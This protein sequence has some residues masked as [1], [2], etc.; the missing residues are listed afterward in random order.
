[1]KPKSIAIVGA[2]ETTRLGVIP[3]MSQIQLHADAALNAMARVILL[4]E[5]SAVLGPWLDRREL[6]GADV[7]AL[8]DQGRLVPAVD[9]VNAQRLRRTMRRE[10]DRIW[11]E[12]DCFI[13]PAT[14][15]TAPRIGDTTVRLGGVDVRFRGNEVVELDLILKHDRV[16]HATACRGGAA[17]KQRTPRDI[18][19]QPH[20]EAD[21]PEPGLD[22][23]PPGPG[24]AHLH[25]SA[26]RDRPIPPGGSTYLPTR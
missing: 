16:S 6:F 20:P 4:S 24:L 5:A 7:M 18:R 9:Y 12:V 15:A 21:F 10:F 2:A 19:Q 13:A 17:G 11:S 14:P 26:A 23:C 25:R 1:M 8:L 3:D 22:R